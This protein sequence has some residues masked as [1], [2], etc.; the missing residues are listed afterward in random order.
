MSGI[1]DAFYSLGS[2]VNKLKADT[3][4]TKV[5]VVSDNLPE[6]ELSMS[7]EELVKLTE[8]W[9]REWNDSPEKAKWD[10]QAKENE[11]YWLGKQ[12][13]KAEIQELR[14]LVDNVI[15]ESVETFLPQATRQNPEAMVSLA[16]SEQETPEAQDYAKKVKLR[17]AD[18]ADELKLRLKIKK[19]ARHWL[20]YLLG[21]AKVGWDVTRDDI[22]VKIIRPQKLILDPKGVND[23]DGY[24]GSRV[25][26]IREMEASILAAIVPKKEKFISDLVKGDMGTR[27]AFKEWWTQEYICWTL[28]DE[29]LLKKKNPHW[30]YDTTKETTQVDDMGNETPMSQPVPGFNHFPAPRIPYIFL[31]VF[32]LG[33]GPID[34]TS[35]ITQNLPLQ[36]WIN[37]LNKQID[38]NIDDMNN[39]LVVSEERSGLTKEQAGQVARAL[40]RKGVV[41]IPTGAP[42]DAIDRFPAAPIPADV[43]NTRNDNRDRLKDVF[44][45]RG[46]NAAGLQKDET[47]RG[48]VLT[49][50]VDTDRIGGGV[51]EYL[52][53]FADDIYNWF[54]QLMYVYY[55]D[56]QG[57][58]PK[59]VVSVKEGS[60]LP[61]DSTS[62]ANQAVDLATAGLMSL[63]DLYKK[64]EDPNPEERAA[65]AWLEKN[66]PQILYSNDPRI[67]Q[68]MQQ[69]QAQAQQQQQ[70]QMEQQGA[71]AQQGQMQSQQ[72]AEM[73]A[74]QHQHTMEQ[75][76]FD[77]QSKMQQQMVK[78]QSDQLLA[79]VK[80]NGKP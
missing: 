41:T 75:K 28:A 46:L 48:K 8:R 47:V 12:F 4:E 80:T 15:F 13:S 69:Q 76:Q 10:E 17:L 49:R 5:G 21:V 37:K 44:G 70:M 34:E 26:E 3:E 57:Q 2:K 32:N 67:A 51:T 31:T 58:H 40:R 72:Q 45:I 18:L 24:S 16:S 65:N 63:L 11:K 66:A 73:A 74:R 27:V 1:L 55:T 22:T 77:H 59:L 50:S 68:V 14:P 29:V 56:Y 52:E 6:L 36:D 19:A 43:Y 71:Q 23:E 61:K 39:G 62:E 54:V 42:R 78:S 79:R 33:K 30:N 7:D 38:A 20:L 35:L 9:E 25:G 64:L 53:Q 60:L